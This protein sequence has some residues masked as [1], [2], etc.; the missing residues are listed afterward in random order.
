MDGRPAAAFFGP[1][2]L[3]SRQVIW[4][5]A[6]QSAHSAAAATVA[7]NDKT[8]GGYLYI[9]PHRIAWVGW[10]E[11]ANRI[12][13]KPN[14]G[15]RKELCRVV[16]CHVVCC[17]MCC[18]GAAGGIG[19]NDDTATRHR[20]SYDTK[21]SSRSII[22][23]RRKQRRSARQ[24]NSRIRGTRAS[25]APCVWT[26]IRH[27]GRGGGIVDTTQTIETGDDDTL[28]QLAPQT[29]TKIPR[30]DASPPRPCSCIIHATHTHTT[31]VA[32]LLC[33]ALQ[34]P[35]P[36]GQLANQEGRSSNRLRSRGSQRYG[37]TEEDKEPNVA[38]FYGE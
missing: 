23:K 3:E 4:R 5:R 17:V 24:L 10:R 20:R 14:R 27:R 35:S 36:R 22:E 32:R 12:E 25:S 13:Q 31:H 11:H 28:Y 7:E 34:D 33:S 15:N 26:W 1:R 6:C 9:H 29:Q 2:R 21:I 16:V 30:T 8:G 38:W 37:G 19:G 18:D